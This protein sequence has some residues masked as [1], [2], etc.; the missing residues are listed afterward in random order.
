M[1]YILVGL[2]NPGEEYTNTRHNTGFLALDAIAKQIGNI[3]APKNGEL[4][5]DWKLDKKNNAYVCKISIGKDSFTLMKP[6]T[7]MNKSGSSLKNII[8]SAKKAEQLIVIHDDLDQP[9]GAVKAVFNRGSGGHRGIESIVRAIKT[10]AFYRIKVGISPITPSGKIKKPLGEAAVEKNILSDFKDAEY[11][12][13]KKVFKKIVE[14]IEI[15]ASEGEEKMI[16]VIN[17]K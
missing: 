12:K 14:G 17:T 7:F 1:N 2:G 16:Q 13:I 8:V 4:S 6:Q 15:L 11:E 3:K 10:E 9:V 5:E